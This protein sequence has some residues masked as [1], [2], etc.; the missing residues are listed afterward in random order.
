[1]CLASDVLHREPGF[2]TGLCPE[3]ITFNTI[4]AFG[5]T[6]N[7]IVNVLR[8]RCP[9]WITIGHRIYLNHASQ[10]TLFLVIVMGL[11]PTE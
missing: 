7:A 2:G 3:S 1:M 8:A 10:G 6:L 5:S 9:A 4:T 11:S